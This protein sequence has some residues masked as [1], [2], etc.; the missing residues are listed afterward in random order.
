MNKK[1]VKLLEELIELQAD[2]QEKYRDA[3]QAREFTRQ[4]AI[5]IICS[6]SKPITYSNNDQLNSS[7]E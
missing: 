5:Q 6:G 1:D 7:K 4:E 3:L 2:L